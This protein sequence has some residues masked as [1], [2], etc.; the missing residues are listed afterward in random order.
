MEAQIADAAKSAEQAQKLS[1]EIAELKR[2]SAEERVDFTLQLAGCRNVKA[3][4]TVLDNYDGDVAKMKE[5]EPW[6]FAKHMS[7]DGASGSTGLPNA[8]AASD[9]GKTMKRWKRLAGLDESDDE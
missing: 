3:A 6:L 1:D 9:G 2:A 8:G 4:R 7:G 5:A